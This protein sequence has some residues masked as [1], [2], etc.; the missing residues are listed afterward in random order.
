MHNRT[1]IFG[2]N[3]WQR[4]IEFNFVLVLLFGRV[5]EYVLVAAGEHALAA[6]VEANAIESHVIGVVIAAHHVHRA[7]LVD[8]VVTAAEQ[9]HAFVVH[10]VVATEQVNALL[11]NVVVTAAEQLFLVVLGVETEKVADRLGQESHD[12]KAR[13]DAALWVARVLDSM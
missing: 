11:V 4:Q 3:V 1:K 2:T 12:H 9:M 6:L 5:G 10:V 13:L 8:V 7:L